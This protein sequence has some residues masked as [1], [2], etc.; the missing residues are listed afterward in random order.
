MGKAL[1]LSLRFAPP[2]VRV[3]HR[4][5]GTIILRS[6]L[7]LGAHA[8]AVGEWLVHWARTAPERNFLA[9]RRGEN[10]R[11]ITYGEA[12]GLVRRLGQGLLDRGLDAAK[13]VLIL[14]DN[15]V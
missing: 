14:S 11:K 7:E 2:E 8:R 15:S 6:P 4:G 1:Q 3:E 10:W 13:P 5:D 9:E 12:L